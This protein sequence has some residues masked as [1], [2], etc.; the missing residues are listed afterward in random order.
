MLKCCLCGEKIEVQA[1]TGWDQ[2]HNAEPLDEGRC[3]DV[4]NEV[5]VIPERLRQMAMRRP[6]VDA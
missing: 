3:C 2:G 6:V 5:K 4:C 1:L